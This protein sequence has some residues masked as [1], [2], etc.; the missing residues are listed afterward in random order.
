M[1]KLRSKNIAE[2]FYV[3]SFSITI[4]FVASHSYTPVSLFSNEKF[5]QI[6]QICTDLDVLFCDSQRHLL[7][8]YGLI[9]SLSFLQTSQILFF[10]HHRSVRYKYL[11]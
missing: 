11:L 3:L 5:P 4:S 7:E 2:F 9:H 10:L 6:T 1:Q 8:I